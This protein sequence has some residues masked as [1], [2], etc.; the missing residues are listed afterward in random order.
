MNSGMRPRFRIKGLVMILVKRKS[1]LSKCCKLIHKTKYKG[2]QLPVSAITCMVYK[3]R[4]K[5]LW[6]LEI[7]FKIILIKIRS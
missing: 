4:N 2:Q 5:I 7:K 3:L 1:S 6:K